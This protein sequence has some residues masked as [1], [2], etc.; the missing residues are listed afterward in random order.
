M[1][2]NRFQTARKSVGKFERSDWFF[3]R[4]D[5]AICNVSMEMIISRV[6]FSL[7]GRK[8]QCHVIN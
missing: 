8:I 4:Q 7:E 2:Q 1:V 6:M 5:F 3:R